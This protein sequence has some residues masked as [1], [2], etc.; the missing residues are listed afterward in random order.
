M[1]DA[2]ADAA[3]GQLSPG[4]WMNNCKISSE[5]PTGITAQVTH[6]IHLPGP[7]PCCSCTVFVHSFLCAAL[8]ALNFYGETR[9]QGWTKASF[10]AFLTYLDTVGVRSVDMWCDCSHCHAK[11]VG[12][13]QTLMDL[14]GAG[15]A[16]LA[17][18]TW[19][20]AAGS[21]LS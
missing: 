13:G 3:S 9:A 8:W 20:R 12:F 6:H 1:L 4:I 16:C 19:T 7:T 10:K 15:R 14:Y 21:P 11:R 2:G 5:Y 17:R 18:T